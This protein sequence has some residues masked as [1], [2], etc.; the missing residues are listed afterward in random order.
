MDLSVVIV[1]WNDVSHL[2]RCLDSISRLSENVDKIVVVDNHSSD[3]SCQRAGEYSRVLLIANQE[4]RGFGP[5]ANQGIARTRSRFVLLINS[6]TR[7]LPASV[8]KLYEA[9]KSNSS[10]AI[11][12]G[13]LVRNDGVPQTSFQFRRLP[14]FSSV[15]FEVSGL[16]KLFTLFQKKKPPPLKSG[17]LPSSVQPAAAYWMVRRGAWEALNGFDPRFWPAWFE[18][19]DFCKRLQSTEWRVFFCE[20]APALHDGGV[21]LPQIGYRRFTQVFYANLKRYLRKHHPYGLALLW[22]PIQCGSLVRQF[23]ATPIQAVKGS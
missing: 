7:V 10:S 5:A 18:D 21:S 15:L 11:A 1:N 19:V 6:D 4:N 9:I 13:S 2:T 23:L 22:F 8:R 3:T 20:D 14:T 12:C 16:D 17:F